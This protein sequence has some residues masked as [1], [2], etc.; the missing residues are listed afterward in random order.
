MGERGRYVLLPE[1]P[2]ATAATTDPRRPRIRRYRLARL[3]VDG[4]A[5]SGAS[6]RRPAG[7]SGHLRRPRD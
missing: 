5:A 4:S 7:E 6:S 3:T 2:A 1:D